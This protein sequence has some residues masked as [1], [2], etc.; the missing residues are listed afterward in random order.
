MNSSLATTEFEALKEY[1]NIKSCSENVKELLDN[2]M[3]VTF[4][5]P[6]NVHRNSHL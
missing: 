2:V 1:I 6:Q 4:A 5:N 3:G